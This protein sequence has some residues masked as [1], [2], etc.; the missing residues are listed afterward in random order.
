MNLSMFTPPSLPLFHIP[1]LPPS[2]FYCYFLS[3]SSLLLIKN[4]V[5][6]ADVGPTWIPN[7]LS[8]HHS[9]PSVIASCSKDIG[10]G[11]NKYVSSHSPLSLPLS[12]SLFLS[13][14]IFRSVILWRLQEDGA[15]AVDLTETTVLPGYHSPLLPLSLFPPIPLPV[16]LPLSPA[17]SPPLP[18]SLLTPFSVLCKRWIFQEVISAICSLELRTKA[19]I[20]RN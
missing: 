11:T 13:L 2:S 5:D 1:S 8:L 4:T 15:V 12:P 16:P 7:R 9:D 10:D 3:P 18:F 17:P 14:I 20:G 19:K 6:E